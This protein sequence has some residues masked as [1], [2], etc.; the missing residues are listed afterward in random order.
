[1]YDREFLGFCNYNERMDEP[2]VIFE[3]ADFVAVVKPAGLLVHRV[4]VGKAKERARKVD[5]A[6]RAEP[7]LADWLV[8]RFPEMAT[9]GDD[10]EYRPGIVHRLDKETSGVMIAARTQAAFERLKRLFQAHAMKKTYLALVAGVPEPERGTIDRPI[11]IKNGT[12]K[13]SVHV[14]TMAKDAVTDYAVKKIY[15]AADNGRDLRA[16]GSPAADGAY[17]PDPRSSREHRTSHSRRP[18]LRREARCRRPGL[19][20]RR[21]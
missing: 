11:G 12:L 3:N 13:R 21:G 5:E 15:R 7:T 1:M 18:S 10:P 16:R 14:K 19:W 2:E 17:A 8:R 20:P 9:V 4:R 6:R